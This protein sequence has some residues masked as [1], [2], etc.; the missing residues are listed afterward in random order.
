MKW[1]VMWFEIC[2]R[3][4]NIVSPPLIELISL[5]VFFIMAI[6]WKYFVFFVGAAMEACCISNRKLF[7][8]LGFCFGLICDFREW[9][10]RKIMWIEEVKLLLILNVNVQVNWLIY[11]S[12]DSC[13]KHK[14]VTNSNYHKLK[15]RKLVTNQ[16]TN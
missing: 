13:L 7:W 10:E 6:L 4:T 5:E 9:E 1:F 8:F 12:Y 16:I 14:Q 3:S 11:K 2:F 15:S